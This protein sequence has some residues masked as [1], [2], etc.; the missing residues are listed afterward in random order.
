MIL[1]FFVTGNRCRRVWKVNDSEANEAH[2]RQRLHQRR[3]RSV[4]RNHLFQHS[5]KVRK[6]KLGPSLLSGSGAHIFFL[7]GVPSFL[8]SM[9]SLFFFFFLLLLLSLRLHQVYLLG[10]ADILFSCMS[11]NDLRKEEGLN[12]SLY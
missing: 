10:L 2:S 7:K 4:Q 3:T 9:Y 1:T 11:V 8:Q 12:I 6:T 5:A